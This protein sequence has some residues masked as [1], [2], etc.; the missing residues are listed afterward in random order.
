MNLEQKTSRTQAPWTRWLKPEAAKE[1]PG[2]ASHK[3][4]KMSAR[5]SVLSNSCWTKATFEEFDKMV[6][7]S[8]TDF[9]MGAEQ[10]LRRMGLSPDMVALRAAL[11]LYL[12][13]IFNRLR[14]IALAGQCRQDS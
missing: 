2:S 1:T 14:R 13:R 4:G 6:T 9:G 7:H 5:R 11:F 10:S 8:C 3:E 12:P